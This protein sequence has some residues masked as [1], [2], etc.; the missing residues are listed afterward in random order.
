L[1]YVFLVF[2]DGVEWSVLHIL[3]KNVIPG[4]P[5]VNPAEPFVGLLLELGNPKEVNLALRL[6]LTPNVPPFHEAQEAH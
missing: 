5:F 6:D 4:F 2:A 3:A 1:T